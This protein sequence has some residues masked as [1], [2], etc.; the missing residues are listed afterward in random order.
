M[1]VRPLKWHDVADNT[2]KP[3]EAAAQYR[4]ATL[5]TAAV[6]VER[7]PCDTRQ[8]AKPQSCH[9]ECCCCSLLAA[10]TFSSARLRSCT[11]T[12]AAGPPEDLLVGHDCLVIARK[13]A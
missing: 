6:K 2:V 13:G 3:R 11:I 9:M 8:K 4:E 12:A 10:D 5:R 7:Y 1:T